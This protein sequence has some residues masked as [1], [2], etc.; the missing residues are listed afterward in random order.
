MSHIQQQTMEMR[1]RNNRIAPNVVNDDPSNTTTINP[2]IPSVSIKKSINLKA[3]I[4]LCLGASFGIIVGLLIAIELTSTT[5]GTRKLQS[6][7]NRLHQLYNS[8]TTSSIFGTPIITLSDANPRAIPPP[9]K[10]WIQNVEE[11]LLDSKLR[12]KLNTEQEQEQQRQINIQGIDLFVPLHIIENKKNCVPLK[13]KPMEFMYHSQDAQDSLVNYVLSSK[14]HG[15]FVE[16]GAGDGLFHS[17]SAFFESQMCWTGLC[18]EPSKHIFNKLILNRKNCISIHGGLCSK[19][20][21]LTK[22]FTDVLSP[23]GWTGWSG[24]AD[25]FT[26]YHK[27][28]IEKKRKEQNWR[29][30]TYNVKCYTLEE[31]M[32][33]YSKESNGGEINY[34]S[35]DTEG[36][37]REIID[38]INF[39]SININGV[40]QVEANLAEVLQLGD[41]NAVL[42]V[43]A[44]RDR[45]AN[46]D[47]HGPLTAR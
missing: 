6:Y 14:S 20:N 38:S 43:Q 29:T 46:F 16:F 39:E 41:T 17:N 7:S 36:S 28:Q 10:T 23:T 9:D 45:M 18:I 35:V 11:S 30:E 32:I 1:T 26:D 33:T 5:Q 22:E 13:E 8:S 44:V 47:F 15:F 19:G 3:I 12:G 24:F 25:T 27:L 34:L 21:G 4:M 42:N 2:N 37:E 31:L 40:V